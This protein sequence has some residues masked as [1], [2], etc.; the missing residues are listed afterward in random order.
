MPGSG[1]LPTARW[2]REKYEPLIK[3][4][5][6]EKMK[7]LSKGRNI[8]VLCDET[9]NRKGEAVFIH[10]KLVGVFRRQNIGVL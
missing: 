10:C 6:D 7:E 3:T 1:D 4:E 5:Y 9:T 2:L 8:A